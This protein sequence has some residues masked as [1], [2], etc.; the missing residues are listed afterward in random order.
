MTER[1]LG[2]NEG[3][4]RVWSKCRSREYMQSGDISVFFD[5]LCD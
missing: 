5:A 2:L 1:V 4:Q 3:T